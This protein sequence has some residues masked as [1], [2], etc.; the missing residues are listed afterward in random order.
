MDLIAQNTETL[1]RELDW[2]TQLVEERMTQYFSEEEADTLPADSIYA[3]GAPILEGDPSVYADICRHYGFG[4]VERSV[5]ILALAPH[6]QPQVLDVFLLRNQ[7][8]D[9]PFS[10]FGGVKGRNHSGYLPTG[11]T[12]AFLVAMHDLQL[13]IRLLQMFGPDHP[14]A[15]FGMLRLEPVPDGEPQLSGALCLGQDF[16]ELCLYGEAAK[17]NY[18]SNFPARLINTNLEWDDLVLPAAV[19][20]QVQVVR[21]WVEQN[22]AIMQAWEPGR[23]LKPGYRALVYGPPGTGKTLTASLIGKSSGKDV[24]LIDASMV[25]SKW[26][27]ETEKNLA[28]VF[29]MAEHKDWILFFDEADA[30]FGKRSSNGSSQEQYSN[31]QVSY[32]LQRT[33]NYPGTVILATNLKAN[34]D[35]AFVRRFQSIIYFPMPTSQDRQLLWEKTFAGGLPL[36]QDINFKEIAKSFEITGGAIVNVLKYCAI[37]AAKRQSAVVMLEDLVEGIRKELAKDGRVA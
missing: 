16:L 37:M 13:R 10:E 2:F 21:T 25:V 7:A 15:R 20:E 19:H 34:I 26:V 14:F 8:T 1:L 29:D 6:L 33:E 28:R 12:A 30:L 22:H 11:E 17:P 4:P 5:L 32:L 36:A 31:Q 23:K 18:S 24:Y 27:G 9:R 3:L 35:E